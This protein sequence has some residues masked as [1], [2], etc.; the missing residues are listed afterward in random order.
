MTFTEQKNWLPWRS[1]V[2]S[3]NFMFSINKFS[4]VIVGACIRANVVVGA[5]IRDYRLF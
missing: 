3:A 1:A 4:N 2:V 5:C